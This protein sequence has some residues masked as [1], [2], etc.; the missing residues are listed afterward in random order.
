MNTRIVLN[1]T[2]DL[3]LFIENKLNEHEQAL[4]DIWNA[5]G[6][7][8]LDNDSSSMVDYHEGA[9]EAL[10]IILFKGKEMYG[11]VH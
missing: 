7:D 1:V 2:E 9:V 11:Q 4:T 3:L 10:S 6:E 5:A 8:I